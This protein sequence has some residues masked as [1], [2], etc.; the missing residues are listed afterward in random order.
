MIVA[1]DWV[2]QAFRRRRAAPS[3]LSTPPLS[4]SLFLV[5]SN[6]FLKP[7][8]RVLI[9]FVCRLCC[10]PF[11]FL[12]RNGHHQATTCIDLLF[13]FC[14]RFSWLLLG[15]YWVFLELDRCSARFWVIYRFIR[16]FTCKDPFFQVLLGSTGFYWV[17]LGFT[18]FY[19]V[20]MGFTGFY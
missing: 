5:F 18:G 7:S 2:W 19:W 9:R 12:L 11:L 8:F 6:F 16:W 10:F 14:R 3:Q 4:L 1:G 17:L 13:G 15:F 20:L